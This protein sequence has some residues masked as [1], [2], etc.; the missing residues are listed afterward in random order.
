MT[1]PKSTAPFN[2]F[3]EAVRFQ[4]SDILRPHLNYLLQDDR[5]ITDEA[6][7]LQYTTSNDPLILYLKE[8][9]LT[10]LLT[11][12]EEVNLAKRIDRAHQAEHKIS[13]YNGRSH[14][15]RN[16]L[17]TEILDGRIAREFFIKANTRLVVSIARKFTGHGVP[18]LDLIQEGNLGLIKA[19]EKFDYQRGF[20]FSTYATWWIRQSV[21]RAISYQGRNIRMP[22]YM[23]D[24]IRHIRNVALEMEQN[25]GRTPTA[26]ELAH[27]L[28]LDSAK[29]DWILQIAQP[30]VSLESPIKDDDSELGMYIE[31]NTSPNPAQI[32]Y[33]NML[34]ER[35][36]EVLA[37]LTPRE[38]RV[39][40]LR[41]GLGHDRAYTLEEVGRKFG[42][43]RE[44]IRQIEGKALHRLRQPAKIRLLRD[45]IDVS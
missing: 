14:K 34:R 5:I 27:Y 33:E 26:Q 9:A 40:R 16:Q 30:T 36:D 25:L 2:R 45:T 8:M 28:D 42:L 7:D 41:F 31:D 43:S 39:L 21:L 11:F 6:T 44:R 35:V 4:D 1:M 38:A 22:V 32:A 15:F 18:F 17:E 10:P 12:E 37:T 3:Y 19:V 24:R 13:S 20:R 23:S 29:L